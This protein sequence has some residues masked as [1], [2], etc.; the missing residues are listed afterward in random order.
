MLEEFVP[1]SSMTWDEYFMHIATTVSIRSK[2]PITKVGAV[3][4]NSDQHIVGTGYNGM[5]KGVDEALLWQADKHKM[6]LHAEQN[7]IAH[8]TSNAKGTTMYV[9]MYPCTSCAKLLVA[10]GVTRIVYSDTKYFN[11]DTAELFDSAGIL[12]DQVVV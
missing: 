9:T 6:V 4:V 8:A 1:L 7:C 11:S 12:V 2:D 5:P 10:A 3:L